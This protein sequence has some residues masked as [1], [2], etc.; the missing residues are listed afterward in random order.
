MVIAFS[1]ILVPKARRQC[2]Y[3]T[4]IIYS[5]CFRKFGVEVEGEELPRKQQV[6]MPWVVWQCQECAVKHFQQYKT[7]GLL[8]ARVQ[9]CYDEARR[10][11]DAADDAYEQFL[12]SQAAKEVAE[13]NRAQWEQMVGAGLDVTEYVNQKLCGTH[14]G[15]GD[16][17]SQAEKLA[18]S[19][20]FRSNAWDSEGNRARREKKRERAVKRGAQAA[21]QAALLAAQQ[22]E[23]QK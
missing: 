5:H 19:L 17:H 2:A 9:A 1:F 12:K 13:W 21:R 10:K 18:Q 11:C 14:G 22:K 16:Y 3:C 4:Q 8:W 20:G 7:D 23:K 15:G 6:R